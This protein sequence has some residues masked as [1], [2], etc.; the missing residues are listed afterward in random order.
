MESI[1]LLGSEI[2]RKGDIVNLSTKLKIALAVVFVTLIVVTVASGVYI[3]I[4]NTRLNSSL[5]NQEELKSSIEQLYATEQSYYLAKDRADKAGVVISEGDSEA[6]IDYFNAFVSSKQE[7][8][9]FGSL[10]IKKKGAE[11]DVIIGSIASMF[12]FIETITNQDYYDNARLD[13]LSFSPDGGYS[14]SLNVA[15]Q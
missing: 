4:N 10:G 8:V 15:R 3:F 2:S 13:E 11:F 9:E 14:V 6:D 5:N 12:G 1:N 7:D